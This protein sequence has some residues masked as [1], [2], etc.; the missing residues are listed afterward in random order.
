MRLRLAVFALLAALLAACTLA[1]SAPGPAVRWAEPLPTDPALV[2]GAVD[3]GLRYVVRRHPNPAG[4]AAFWLHVAAGS[5]DEEEHT[6]GLAHYLE[7]MAFNGSANFPPGALIPYF[8]SIGLSF[9]RDQNAFTSLDQTV[10]QIAVPDT[11]AETLGRALLYLGDVATRLSLASEEIERERQIILEEKRARA[12]ADQRVSDYVIER[13]APGSTF[14]RRL[15]I[16]TEETIKGLRPEH[17]RD[18]YARHYRPSNMTLLAVCDCD[19]DLVVDQIRREFGEAPRAPRPPP[20]TLAVTRTV[21][22]RGVVA[23]DRDLT[24]ASVSLTRVEPP[25]A[26]TTTLEQAR[27][28]L[29]ERLGVRAFNRRL[30][31][32]LAAG[33]ATF[34]DATGRVADWG[35]A[36][37]LVSVRA[38]GPPERWR[39]MLEELGAAVQQAR[40]HGFTAREL[41]VVRRAVLAEAEEAV[42]RQPTQPARAVLRQ[43]NDGVA[44]GEPLMSAEQRRAVLERVLPG[45]DAVEVSRTFAATFDFSSV[46]IVASLPS[47]AGVPDEEAVAAAGRSALLARVEAEPDVAAEARLLERPPR[48][49]R[50]VERGEHAGSGVTSAWLDN[51]VRAHHRFVDQRR[52]EVRVRITLAGGEIEETAATRGVTRAAALAWQRPATST[53]TSTQVR[54]LMTG[55]RVRV[56]GGADADSLTLVVSGDPAELEHGLQLAYRLLTDPVIEAAALGQWQESE[57]QAITARRSRPAGVLGETL[58]DAIYPAAELRTRPLTAGQ[59]RAVTREA[60]QAWLARLI[61]TAPIE[62]AVV[63]DLERERALD[64]VARYLGALPPRARIGATTLGGLRA[65]ARPAGPITRARA[66][67]TA[68]SQAVVLDGFFGADVTNVRD[69]RLLALAAQVLTTRMN[70]IVREERQLVYSIHAASRP[71]AEYPGYG[72]FVAQAPTDPGKTAALA[73]TLEELF[74]A[75]ATAG[76][77]DGEIRVARVQI[78]NALAETLAGPDFWVDRLASLD[79]RGLRL[80]DVMEARARY[81]AM[82]AAEV[83]EA[84]ARYYAPAARVRII[85]T[86]D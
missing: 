64:L 26:P 48:A 12:S 35:R 36:V 67:S 10:Y 69:T 46:V 59:V 56:H 23:T 32:R 13:L 24:R 18:F 29:V 68:T 79:Y 55:R 21:G 74:T 65:I 31:T 82:T 17:F 22:V 30:D 42:Q 53:L 28:D 3:G 77:T 70:R 14:G 16:G 20:R 78:D 47:G 43:L 60:A 40:V 54:E 41:E 27:R 19:P 83:R 39:A 2:T 80:D 61:G 76:P 45:I 15:P 49:G 66:V 75:F 7:H 44:R 57:V 6:R 25:P 33:R 9:G 73:A 38:S 85:V 37:R 5:L 58:A 50:V 84:F 81:A 52:N 86:P 11:R 62:V 71:A 34:L 1:P 51:G 4:R 8:E 72:L 63:G